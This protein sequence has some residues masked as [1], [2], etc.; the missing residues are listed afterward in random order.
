MPDDVSVMGYDDSHFAQI[1]EVKLTSVKHPK[2]IMGKAAAK[3][4]IDC[5][6]HKTEEG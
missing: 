3:Y 2:S 1:S 4:V 6:E 5:L